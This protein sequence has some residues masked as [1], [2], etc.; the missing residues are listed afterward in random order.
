MARVKSQEE[1][2]KWREAIEKQQASGLSKTKWCK[3]HGLSSDMLYYWTKRLVP[4]TKITPIFSELS[5]RTPSIIYLEY[6]NIKIQISESNYD[7]KFLK[8][9]LNDLGALC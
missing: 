2:D 8:T 7:P 9:L 3:Q 1:K 6:K 5:Q 4:K